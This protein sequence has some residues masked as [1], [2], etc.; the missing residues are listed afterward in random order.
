MDGWNSLTYCPG[1]KETRDNDRLQGAVEGVDK[2]FPGLLS[3]PSVQINT[4]AAA[5][6]SKKRKD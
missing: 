2:K 1:I 3:S 4:K 6:P 5:L